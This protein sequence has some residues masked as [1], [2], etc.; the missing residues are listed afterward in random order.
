MKKIPQEAIDRRN[1]S[2]SESVKV[3]DSDKNEYFFD[4]L[5]DAV[6]FT[7]VNSKQIKNLAYNM[8][9][10]RRGFMFFL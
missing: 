9:A 5:K 1:Q 8:K 2:N 6:K 10:S 3:V 4:K 7:G